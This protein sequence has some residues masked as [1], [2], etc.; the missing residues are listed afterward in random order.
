MIQF[1]FH[2]SELTEVHLHTE[3]QTPNICPS[4]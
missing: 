3:Q 1:S 4:W 2:V